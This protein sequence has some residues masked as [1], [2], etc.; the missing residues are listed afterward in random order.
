[1]HGTFWGY[2]CWMFRVWAGS[3]GSRSEGFREWIEQVVCIVVMT[4]GVL[5]VDPGH[6]MAASHGPGPVLVPPPTPDSL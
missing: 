1:M 3:I 5:I 2:G 4:H 6:I